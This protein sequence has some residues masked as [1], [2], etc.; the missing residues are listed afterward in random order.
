MGADTVVAG[1]PASCREAARRLLALSTTAEQA[2]ATLSAQARIPEEEFAG[3]AADGYRQT[4]SLLSDGALSTS[5]RSRAVAD[6]LAA[7]ADTLRE[8]QDVMARA[9]TVAAHYGLLNGT[10]VEAPPAGAEAR[11]VRAH[12]VVVG[13]MADARD[14][15]A[16]AEARLRT[17]V[18]EHAGGDLS[19]MP[20][21]STGE[22]VPS[23][24]ADAPASLRPTWPPPEAAWPSAPRW[25]EAPQLPGVGPSYYQS[26]PHERPDDPPPRDP[27]APDRGRTDQGP[28]RGWSPGPERVAPDETP[29]SASA[30]AGPSSTVPGA[31]PAVLTPAPDAPPGPLPDPLR[32]DPAGGWSCRVPPSAGPVAS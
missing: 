10:V 18:A 12:D 3:E 30:P 2:H 11:V 23:R 8:V 9:R 26:G 17:I 29:V 28:P 4:S 24:F 5:L 27:P 14:V 32:P 7:Y 25:E 20:D 31:G 15:L 13:H 6:G 19:T 1:D 21:H 16:T 22:I